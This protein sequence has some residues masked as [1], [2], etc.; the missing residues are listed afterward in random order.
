MLQLNGNTICFRKDVV[1]H[2]QQHYGLVKGKRLKKIKEDF[3]GSLVCNI[4]NYFEYKE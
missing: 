1:S 3:R 2:L 4:I